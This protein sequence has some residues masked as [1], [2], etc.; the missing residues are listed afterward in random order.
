MSD[1][2]AKVLADVSRHSLDFC[3]RM[4]IDKDGV[5]MHV[6]DA[7]DAI[8]KLGAGDGLVERAE[9]ALEGVTDGPW[10]AV[11]NRQ[12]WGWVEVDGPSFKI[13]APT[14]A[15]DLTLADEAQRKRDARF[16]AFTR[17]WVPEAAARIAALTAQVEEL[18]GVRRED[19]LELLASHGQ[20]QEAY[21]AQLDAEA[22]AAALR[23]KVARL[24]G[25]L[26]GV[27]SAAQQML[28][29]AQKTGVLDNILPEIFP[30]AKTRGTRADMGLKQL[31]AA[32]NNLRAHI[33]TARAALT[34]GGKDG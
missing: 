20:A 8:A 33:S 16:I 24:E 18:R 5:W 13:G 15:T 17:Q 21:A 31:D 1:W 11:Y 25:A 32:R 2:A 6:D 12:T 9:A 29:E 30:D 7:I 22:E 28:S 34:D 10:E 27:T 14:Q 19:A 23:A 4:E 26:E 3:D